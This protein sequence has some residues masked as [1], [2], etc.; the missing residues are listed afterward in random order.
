MCF[1]K[2]TIF[3]LIIVVSTL[4]LKAQYTSEQVREIDSLNQIITESKYD[5]AIARAYLGLSHILFYGNI[6]TVIP[7]SEKVIQIVDY[8][9]NKGTISLLEEKVL[10][11]KKASALNDMGYIYNI[12]GELERA[13]EYY[14]NSLL[15]SIEAEDSVAMTSVLN[16]IG[17][18]YQSQGEYS[19]ALDHHNRSMRLAEKIG[20]KKS[21]GIS[22]SNIGTIY[23]YQGDEIKALNFFLKGLKIQEEIDDQEGIGVALN[24]IASIYFNQKDYEASSEYQHKA[25]KILQKVGDKKG[26][27]SCLSNIGKNLEFQENFFSALDYFKKAM[28]IAKEIGYKYGIALS[29]NNIGGTYYVMEDYNNAIKYHSNALNMMHELKEEAGVIRSLEHLS[30]AHL[31]L[32]NTTK[33]K[34]YA[35]KAWENSKKIG[36][37]K[38]ISKSARL[39]SE[40]YQIEKDYKKS[41]EYYKTFIVMRDSTINEKTAKKTMEQVLRYEYEKKQLADSLLNR[42]KDIR[43]QHQQ[44][45]LNQEKK[46]RY[47]SVVIVFFLF[48]LG[49]LIF[50]RYRLSLREK[51]NKILISQLETEQKLLRAQMN[52]HFIFNSINSIQSY[53]LDNESNIARG[54]LVKFSK[55]IRS[56]LDQ[57]GKQKIELSE[58]IESLAVYLEL[59][60]L[61]FPNKFT[62]NIDVLEGLSLDAVSI[63]PLLIQPFVENAV[64]HGIRHKE[65]NGHIAISF[66]K[67]LNNLVCIVEDNGVGRAY[68]KQMNQKRKHNS[69][70]IKLVTDRLRQ[71]NVN[72]KDEGLSI[73]DLK[74]SKGIALGT[75][76]EIK[77]PMA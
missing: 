32:E 43:I 1:R 31:K 47:A 10:K 30:K 3:T 36:R 59:E 15:L 72:N 9:L 6:D 76:V 7:L 68:T 48:I 12:K 69:V 40:I 53:I 62:F 37:V 54:Y 25:L 38:N 70:A 51:Q 23:V 63:P 56:V 8:N 60:Q 57:T 77:I 71:L 20:D 50:N 5:T 42:E 58:E 19:T 24:N 27:Y 52:P 28:E 75:R 2:S 33:A 73:K 13:V 35:E 74:D 46:L 34:E 14:N 67:D 66:S 41:L 11:G 39:M 64:L 22:L 29:M 55:L 17:Y 16:N 65:K 45:Q 26:V 61:R 44:L 18:V 21:V 49:V 4:S